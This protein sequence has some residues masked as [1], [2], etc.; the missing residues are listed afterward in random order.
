MKKTAQNFNRPRIP[1]Q[2]KAMRANFSNA[3]LKNV[4]HIDLEH[5][6]HKETLPWTTYTDKYKVR[7]KNRDFT[8]PDGYR[9]LDFVGE[10]ASCIV[11]RVAN[12]AGVP[13]ALKLPDMNCWYSSVA[14]RMNHN[15]FFSEVVCRNIL[16][17]SRPQFYKIP[18]VIKANWTPGNEYIL[19]ELAIG[20]PIDGFESQAAP[21][22]AE[23]IQNCANPPANLRHLLDFLP[24]L[25][26]NSAEDYPTANI[27][28]LPAHGLENSMIHDDLEP[29]NIIYDT[30]DRKPWIFDFTDAGRGTSDD[31]IHRLLRF[32]PP[33]LLKPVCHHLQRYCK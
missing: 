6:V 29:R 4:F 31:N 9:I 32:L 14:G 28:H 25:P 20:V 13:F 5:P 22:I 17:A 2:A 16:H 1:P 18:E 8:V 33:L 26:A 11:F 27:V 30:R 12:A 21:G 10:G 19:E 23:F 15:G 24:T 3:E 7:L